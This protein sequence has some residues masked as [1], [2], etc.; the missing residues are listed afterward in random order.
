MAYYTRTSDGDD[1]YGDYDGSP[2]WDN[3][4]SSYDT[5][6][7][8][9]PSLKKPSFDWR[10]AGAGALNV[11]VVQAGGAAFGG[12]LNSAHSAAQGAFWGAVVTGVY[13]AF[14]F[15]LDADRESRIGVLGVVAAEFALAGAGAYYNVPSAV[16]QPAETFSLMR[17]SE[18]VAKEQ[19]VKIER[20]NAGKTVAA[21]VALAPKPL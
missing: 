8:P 17:P 13:G 15:S 14:A 11:L 19:S 4:V 5:D 7:E 6:Y 3:S 1:P 21:T 9:S 2:S 18:E 16:F 12:L 20:D 10:E